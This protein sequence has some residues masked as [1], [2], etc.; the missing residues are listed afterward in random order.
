MFQKMLSIHTDGNFSYTSVDLMRVSC[1]KKEVI[2]IFTNAHLTKVHAVYYPK[3]KRLGNKI[4]KPHV[5]FNQLIK[6]KWGLKKNEY[7]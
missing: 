1:R 5:I 3:P 2:N 4:L 6:N 7:Y